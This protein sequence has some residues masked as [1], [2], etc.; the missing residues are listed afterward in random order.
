MTCFQRGRIRSRDAHSAARGQLVEI[1]RNLGGFVF[2]HGN[3]GRNPLMDEHRNGEFPAGER[4]DTLQALSSPRLSDTHGALAASLIAI[5]P[6][7]FFMRSALGRLGRKLTP[8]L[9]V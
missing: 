5:F 3:A 8:A 2:H 6:N 4:R 1:V 9:A 7:V